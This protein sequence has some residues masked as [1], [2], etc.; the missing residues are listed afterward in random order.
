MCAH[1][2]ARGGGVS[3]RYGVDDMPM[4]PPQPLGGS[5]PRAQT[6]GSGLGCSLDR[7]AQPRHHRRDDGVAGCLRQ[8]LVEAR[9]ES[10]EFARGRDSASIASRMPVISAR[11]ASVRAS[12]SATSHSSTTRVRTTSLRGKPFAATCRRRNA[13]SPPARGGHDHRPRRGTGTGRRTHDTEHLEHA[14]GLA[15]ARTTH[16]QLRGQFSRSG[17]SRSPGRR[18]PSRRSPSIR[19]STTCHARGALSG[20]RF[21]LRPARHVANHITL[22]ARGHSEAVV[23]TRR[24][25]VCQ[26]Q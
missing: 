4:H 15:H 12:R 14:H 26:F 11:S 13:A 2:L 25:I 20:M 5:R 1:A 8:R 18:R 21:P 10:E 3:A 6:S 24:F 16:A 19:S 22:R 17:G 9:V 7:A 23:C